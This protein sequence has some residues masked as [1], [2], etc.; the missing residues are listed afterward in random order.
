MCHMITIRIQMGIPGILPLLHFI[1]IPLS[2][3][4]LGY[5]QYTLPHKLVILLTVQC[6]A[7]PRL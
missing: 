6:E 7:V 2:N 1:I 3:N 4:Q 5:I